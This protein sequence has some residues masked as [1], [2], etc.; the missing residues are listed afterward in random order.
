MMPLLGVHGLPPLPSLFL[1]LL[2]QCLIAL[3]DFLCSPA[4]FLGMA[5]S[6]GFQ[7]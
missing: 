7:S 3:I 6:I 5:R 2:D 4:A 1:A